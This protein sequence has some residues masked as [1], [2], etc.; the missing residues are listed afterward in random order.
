MSLDAGATLD[1]R[2]FTALEENQGDVSN[3]TF[4]VQELRHLLKNPELLPPDGCAMVLNLHIPDP[5]FAPDGVY[6]AGARQYRIAF[7]KT[8]ALSSRA[9]LIIVGFC[10]RKQAGA[11]R[12]IVETVDQELVAEFPAHPH[13]LGYNSLELAHGDWCNLVLFNH[14]DGLA[15][16]STSVRHWQAVREIAPHYY[17]YIRLHNGIIPGGLTTT[18]PLILRRTKYYDFSTGEMWHAVRE[19]RVQ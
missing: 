11:D 5:R 9:D 13:F 8:A 18:S 6:T 16:W 14:W 7:L 15:H 4:M 10:G 12:T 17:Q 2:P 19:Y 1:N 3:L